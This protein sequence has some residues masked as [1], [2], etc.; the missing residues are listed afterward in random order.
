MK[1]SKAPFTI[2]SGGNH[3]HII[4]D[5]G[6]LIARLEGRS[7]EAIKR[8]QGKANAYLFAA[9]PDLLKTLKDLVHCIRDFQLGDYSP[10]MDEIFDAEEAICRAETGKTKLGEI[11]FQPK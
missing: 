10:L 8:A 9:A 6:D 5:N 3:R 4:D 11:A 7:H 2:E 1:H